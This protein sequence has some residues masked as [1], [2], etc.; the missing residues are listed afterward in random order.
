MDG[1]DDGVR[2]ARRASDPTGR[3]SSVRIEIV[4]IFLIVVLAILNAARILI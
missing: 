4:A 3:Y 2:R 1:S